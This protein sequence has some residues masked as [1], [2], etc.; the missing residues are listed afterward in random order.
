MIP[1]PLRG[2]SEQMCCS[3]TIGRAP[4]ALHRAFPQR[5][6]DIGKALHLQAVR[7]ASAISAITSMMSTLIAA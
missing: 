2:S 6:A 4:S 7:S 5:G 1:P 3:T